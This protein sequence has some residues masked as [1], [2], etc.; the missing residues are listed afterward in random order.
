MQSIS[1]DLKTAI[2]KLIIAEQLKKTGPINYCLFV[3]E[4][5]PKLKALIVKPDVS[6]IT[7]KDFN[8]I[9]PKNLLINTKE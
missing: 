8:K 4:Y 9:I 5:L 1:K 2:K 7:L 6:K 3:S